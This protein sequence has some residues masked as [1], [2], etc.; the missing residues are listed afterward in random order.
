MGKK[1]PQVEVKKPKQNGKEDKTY[2]APEFDWE[3]MDK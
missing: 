3:N 1:E 2:V